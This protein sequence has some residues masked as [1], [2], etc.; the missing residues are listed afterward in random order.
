MWTIYEWVTESIQSKSS[1]RSEILF[2]NMKNDPYKGE[3][4][5]T[6][7][8]KCGDFN[9][10]HANAALSAIHTACQNLKWKSRCNSFYGS[11]TNE[12]DSVCLIRARRTGSW[13]DSVSTFSCWH[14]MCAGGTA[15]LIKNVKPLLSWSTGLLGLRS[16]LRRRPA[17]VREWSVVINYRLLLYSNR[18]TLREPR[19]C[20]LRLNPMAAHGSRQWSG[21]TDWEPRP[22]CRTIA[23][24]P[25][26]A[27][28][29]Q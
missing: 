27:P 16:E 8:N 9:S 19:Q 10:R 17:A 2:W 25:P 14:V 5:I 13:K 26:D 28:R 18:T 21:T 1:P 15:R 29:L 6:L 24:V 12:V 7:K 11:S 22:R 4:F 3:Y 20:T 23:S